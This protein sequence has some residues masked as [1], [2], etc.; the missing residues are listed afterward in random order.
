MRFY[1]AKNISV[2]TQISDKIIS[3]GKVESRSPVAFNFNGA[4]SQF[5]LFNEF[6]V[7]TRIFDSFAWRK[8]KVSKASETLIADDCEQS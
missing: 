8:V 1:T 5:Y 3:R 2:S 4:L 6:S 7:F